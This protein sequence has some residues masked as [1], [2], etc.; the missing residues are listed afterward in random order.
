MLFVKKK[1]N[2]TKKIKTKTHKIQ[3]LTFLIFK[4]IKNKQKTNVMTDKTIITSDIKL[5]L[6]VQIVSTEFFKL[7]VVVKFLKKFTAIRKVISRV[8]R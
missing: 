1:H 3:L 4:S 6:I 8:N 2:N 5:S 7:T